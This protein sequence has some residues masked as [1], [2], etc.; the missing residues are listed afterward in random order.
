MRGNV[1][2]RAKGT[3]TLTFE[4]PPDPATG[5]RRQGYET[6]RGT[7]RDAL[8]RLNELEAQVHKGEYVTPGRMTVG[9]FLDQWLDSHVETTTRATTANGY[10]GNVRR[11]I[12]P[13]LGHLVLTKLQPAHIQELL[14]E[15]SARGLSTRTVG[16]CRTVL[17]NAL[18]RAVQW[19]LIARNP[20]DAT[21]PP[22]SK[23]KDMRTLMPEEVERLL[24][25]ARDSE[26]YPAIFTALWTGMR[27]SELLGL[28]WRD[29]DLI[30][31]SISVSQVTHRLPGARTVYEDPK[32]S[33]G[34]RYISMPPSLTITLSEHRE[35]QAAFRGKLGRDLDLDDLVF[36][37][38]DGRPMLPDSLSHAFLKIARRA[39]VEVRLHDMRHTHASLMLREGV[40]P[41]V[42]Q[43][44]LGHSNIGITMDTYSH[45]MPGLQEAAAEKF[46]KALAMA[47]PERANEVSGEPSLTNR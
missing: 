34:K 35:R 37:W 14:A 19:G 1:R 22:R 40:S 7:K 13:K 6:V 23:T 33:A 8:C 44:R 46:D 31:G 11:Y 43:E 30:L 16:Q 17:R 39:G 45:V 21:S 32:S 25:A 10:A 42:I 47:I 18:G 26:Y 20:A 24:T 41:K 12:R 27:R 2:Q 3:W 15:M 29:L 4:L 9:S 38:P 36:T 5:K 28:R